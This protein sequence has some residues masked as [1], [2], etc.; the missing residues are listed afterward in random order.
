MHSVQ[1][2]VIIKTGAKSHALS[3]T[4]KKFCFL[5]IGVKTG[6]LTEAEYRKEGAY[7][8]CQDS[9]VLCRNLLYKVSGR[10]SRAVG[11]CRLG[12]QS[13]SR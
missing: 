9:A 6:T 11:K 8:I 13:T 4:A 3:I 1:G 10:L 5:H 7:I 12:P 2:L